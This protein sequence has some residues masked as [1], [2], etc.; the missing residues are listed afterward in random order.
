M[1]TFKLIEETD[2]RLVFWYYPEG[3]E[4]KKPGTI[5]VDRIKEEIDITEL[6]E[7]DWEHVIP[8]EEINELVDAINRMKQEQGETDYVEPVTEPEHSI[9]YGDHA[10]NEIIEHL[11]KGEIPKKGMQAWY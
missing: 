10:V 4:D 6:A 9:Y 8:L 3:Y 11:H 7:D 1:V 5:I 2:A